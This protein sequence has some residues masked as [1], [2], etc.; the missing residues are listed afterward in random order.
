MTQAG[1]TVALLLLLSLAANAQGVT[2]T[3]A[4]AADTVE[5]GAV[6]RLEYFFEDLDPGAFAL[7]ELV[8]L[9]AV[10]GPSTQSQVQI[11]NGARS[12][13]VRY[14]YRVVADQ[15]GLAYVPAV[16][17][18]HGGETYRSE[19]IELHVTADPTYVPV[20]ERLERQ[21]PLPN[22]PTPPRPPRPRVRM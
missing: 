12:S 11:V 14:V 4:P 6:L 9:V 18:E 19:A 13:A 10:G 5:Q 22:T 2:T 8:G 16:E 21:R 3:L 17:L 20:A 1:C 7:P 15:P